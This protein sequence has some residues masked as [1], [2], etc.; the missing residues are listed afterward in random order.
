[1]AIRL[2]SR[3]P[4]APE[5]KLKVLFEEKP[6]PKKLLIKPNVKH[7]IDYKIADLF[8]KQCK[9]KLK[10]SFSSYLKGD[11]LNFQ[12][13]NERIAFL[14]HFNFFITTALA[15]YTPQKIKTIN[16]VEVGN[17]LKAATEYARNKL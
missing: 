16:V 2:F 17:L 14:N 6:K 15:N 9:E 1:M 13:N 12:K 5:H 11:L 7:T 8:E 4:K 10:Q 3:K